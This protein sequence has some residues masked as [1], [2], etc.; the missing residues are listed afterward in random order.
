[1][2]SEIVMS[3]SK[4]CKLSPDSVIMITPAPNANGA[5]AGDGLSGEEVRAPLTGKMYP[6][7]PR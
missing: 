1:M 3:P 7:S 4:K 6:C 2:S 5:T